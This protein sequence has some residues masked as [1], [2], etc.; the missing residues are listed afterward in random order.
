MK[1]NKK[2]VT[3]MLCAVA[4]VSIFAT[5]GCGSSNDKAKDSNVFKVGME[6]GY[7]PYNWS[8]T[9]DENNAVKI[10]GTSEYASGYDVMVAQK[11]AD[12][13]GKKLE[14]H[15]IDWN[16]LAPAVKSGKID[17]V[18]AGMSITNKRKTSVDFSLP[19]YYASVVTMTTKDSK[20][21]NAKGLSD[22]KGAKATSQMNTIWY[23][24]MV[25]QIPEVQKLPAISTVPGMVVALTS[26]KVDL[27]VADLPAAMAAQA[28]NPKIV[29]LNFTGQKDNYEFNNEDVEIGAAIKKGNKELAD[30]INKTLKNMTQEDFNKIMKK[31]IEIQPMAEKK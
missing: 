15:K 1:L 22:L 30:S 16:G 27:L 6:C 29:I 26:G 3:V 14:I 18:L 4:A 5:A 20:Y 9:T 24:K 13:M 31:A 19:Y 2:I 11:I 17:A 8:Q 23:T 21:A 28:S 7:A 10:A 12:D 25:D